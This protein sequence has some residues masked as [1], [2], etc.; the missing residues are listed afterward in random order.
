MIAH[1]ISQ[2]EQALTLFLIGLGHDAHDG[3]ASHSDS[4]QGVYKQVPSSQTKGEWIVIASLNQ[5][6][7]GMELETPT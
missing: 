1:S 4:I 3:A 7:N 2:E 6:E 5:P